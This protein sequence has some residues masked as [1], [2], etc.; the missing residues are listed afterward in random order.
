MYRREELLKIFFGRELAKSG[1]INFAFVCVV[2]RAFLLPFWIR[3]VN[4]QWQVGLE[5]T[6]VKFKSVVSGG[7]RDSEQHTQ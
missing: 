5:F 7:L 1:N 4:V 2:I 3:D 6:T